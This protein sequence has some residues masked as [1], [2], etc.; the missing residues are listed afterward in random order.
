MGGAK[1]KTILR[2]GSDQSGKPFARAFS[3]MV[4]IEMPT[5]MTASLIQMKTHRASLPANAAT[6]VAMSADTPMS[7]I[8]Q[9]D[10][11]VNVAA[12]AIVSRMNW[13]LSMARACISG[14][15]AGRR[16]STRVI[17]GEWWS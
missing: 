12:A 16:G 7:I 14:A 17:R 2:A 11:A 13:R 6:T 15:S 5:D 4:Y 3:I 10:T 8:P 1:L 9:P